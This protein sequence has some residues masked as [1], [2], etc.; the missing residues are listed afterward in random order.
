MQ[1]LMALDIS[2][3][4]TGCCIG[5]DAGPRFMSTFDCRKAWDARNQPG[6]RYVRYQDWLADQITVHE[7]RA[8]LFEAPLPPQA[9]N[10]VDTARQ[11]LG[12]V[13]LTEAMAHRREIQIVGEVNSQAVRKFF[14][15]TG[16]AKKE[17]VIAECVH[18]GWK[19]ADH[20]Q[21]DAAAVFAYGIA[22]P[23]TARLWK[24]DA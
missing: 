5:D 22:S 14:C 9:F 17:D 13:A 7:P 19:I 6:G 23:T 4:G 11:L 10:S 16:R 3:S 20:N 12:L 18:R 2:I 8:L 24:V 15:G 21:A 1:L